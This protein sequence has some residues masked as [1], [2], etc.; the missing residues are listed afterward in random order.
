[1]RRDK[2]APVVWPDR[3]AAAEGLANARNGRWTSVLL[4]LVASWLVGSSGA[5]NALEVGRLVSVERE[6]VAAGGRTFVVEPSD[7][8]ERGGI[9]VALCDRLV[10]VD[11]VTGSFSTLSTSAAAAPRSAPGHRATIVQVSPG[12]HRF[13]DVTAARGAGVIAT[14]EM[15]ARTGVRDGEVVTLDISAFDG[16]VLPAT[17]TATA[18][19]RVLDSPAL[20]ADLREAWLVPELLAGAASRCYVA[21]DAAHLSSVQAHLGQ[22]LAAHDGTP[23]VVRPR[24]AGSTYGLELAGAY[25]QRPLAGASVFGGAMLTVLFIVVRWHHRG[26][27]AV[28]RTFGAHRRALLLIQLAEWLVLT[29]VGCA[30]GWATSVAL[31]IG[32]AVDVHVVVVQATAH[33]AVTWASGT[34]GVIAAA[35]LP[36]GTLLD[37]LKDR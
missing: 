14:S 26:Q 15:V 19:L 21:T 13:F 23:A 6:W 22:A 8:S 25:A 31:G 2:R 1:M 28:Y 20:A 5:A 10:D 4:V 30:W 37:T 24:L 17:A 11:G 32:Q 33:A 16:A 29:A 36:T 34:L 12:V 7:P 35:M 18:E 9:D 3:L 27:W